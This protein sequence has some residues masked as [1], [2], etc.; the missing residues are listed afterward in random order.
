MD[1]HAAVLAQLRLA[2]PI[3]GGGAVAFVG[4]EDA[5]VAKEPHAA[6]QGQAGRQMHDRREPLGFAARAQLAFQHARVEGEL[7][8]AGCGEGQPPM[9]GWIVTCAW[10]RDIPH[11]PRA[12]ASL[13]IAA[14]RSRSRES[15]WQVAHRLRRCGGAAGLRSLV[16]NSVD[17][18]DH[19]VH[20]ASGFIGLHPSASQGG[21]VAH[22]AFVELHILFSQVGGVD[23]RAGPAEVEIDMEVKFFRGDRGAERLE[24]G[25]GRLAALE[26]PEDLAAAGRAVADVHLLLDD[27]RGA[28]A[29]GSD[30]AAPVGVAA[31]PTGLDERAVRHGPRR[32]IG[33]GEGLRA[34]DPHGDEPRDAF[35]IAHDHLGQ[36]QADVAQ[37]GLEKSEVRSPKSEVP[38][39]GE[40][41]GQDEHGVV[42]AHVAVHR[43]AVEAVGDGLAQ[44]GLQDLCLDRGIGGD[45]AEHRGVERHGRGAL[46]GGAHAGLNHAGAFADAADADGLAAQLE[47]HGDLF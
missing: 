7:V 15:R 42:R 26:A 13:R 34:V 8:R 20:A 5:V 39:A 16:R 29:H 23:D 9:P 17:A 33:I 36:L 10:A 18:L 12:T 14:R 6:V 3:P 40:A 38:V 19:R 24:G 28:V 2:R 41:I 22:I 43:D 1:F 21:W 37:G 35:A 46:A 44:G 4:A 27:R 11:I 45:E 47:L 25:L 31:V 30:D 32:G